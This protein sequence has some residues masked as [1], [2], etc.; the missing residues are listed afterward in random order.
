MTGMRRFLAGETIV[1]LLS[2]SVVFVSTGT[3]LTQAP[4]R[5]DRTD[6]TAGSPSFA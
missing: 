5:R 1:P 2:L 3:S 6:G 4:A